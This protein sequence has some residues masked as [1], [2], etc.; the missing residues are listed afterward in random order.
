MEL[1]CATPRFYENFLRMAGSEIGR[2]ETRADSV[3]VKTLQ[4]PYSI[5]A[6]LNLNDLITSSTSIV[7]E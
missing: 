7:I 6:A 2:S 3:F 5:L 1:K 4:Q